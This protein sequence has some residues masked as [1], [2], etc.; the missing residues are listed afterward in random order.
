MAF[1][2]NGFRRN[3]MD[4]GYRASA[5][6]D[7]CES[8]IKPMIE[9]YYNVRSQIGHFLC[10]LVLLDTL[11]VIQYIYMYL[12][13]KRNKIAKKVTGKH[14]TCKWYDNCFGELYLL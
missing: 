9:V 4:P 14:L 3:V 6:F 13:I 2:R 12:L 7:L 8:E 10:F 1:R 11:H 5:N